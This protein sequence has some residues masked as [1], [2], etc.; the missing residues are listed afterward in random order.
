MAN[1]TLGSQSAINGG[2]APEYTNIWLNL[3]NSI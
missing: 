3:R 2:N 1:I